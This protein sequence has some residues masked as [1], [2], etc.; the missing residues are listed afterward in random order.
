MS[1]ARWAFILSVAEGALVSAE[2]SKRPQF[3]FLAEKVRFP[4]FSVNLSPK[5]KF[6]VLS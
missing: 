3:M 6:K 4:E 2:P 1:S 5:L